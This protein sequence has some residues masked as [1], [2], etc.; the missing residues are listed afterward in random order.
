[1]I[2][3]AASLISGMFPCLD[4]KR[5]VAV[6]LLRRKHK[7]LM[8]YWQTNLPGCRTVHVTEF[9]TRE[10]HSGVVVHFFGA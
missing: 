7:L 9:I 1:M 3:P 5:S 4:W 10:P 8:V 2:E 6:D